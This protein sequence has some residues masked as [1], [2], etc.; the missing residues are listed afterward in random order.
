MKMKKKKQ[1]TCSLQKIKGFWRAP[2]LQ[3]SSYADPGKK[4]KKKGKYTY[5]EGL[6]RHV[7]NAEIWSYD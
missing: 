3:L 5:R 2:L 1:K 4:K 7:G 6:M